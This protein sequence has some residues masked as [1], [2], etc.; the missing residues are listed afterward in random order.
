VGFQ[1]VVGTEET[2]AYVLVAYATRDRH[3]D[4]YKAQG[5]LWKYIWGFGALSAGH[6]MASYGFRLGTFRQMCVS[7]FALLH[8]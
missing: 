8:L 3:L 1:L 4:W 7:V 2:L 5:W 6:F